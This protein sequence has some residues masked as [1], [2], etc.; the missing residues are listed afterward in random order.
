MVSAWGISR[1][2]TLFSLK[3]H[4]S[5]YFID[6]DAMRING[7][8]AL[9][10][11]ETPGWAVPAG[12]E[13]ATIYSD[14]YKLGL[15]ALRL[16]AGHHDTKILAHLP[17]TTPGLLR[18]TITDTL[19]NEPQRR[20]LP[21]AWNYVLGHAIEQAQHQKKIAAATGAPL[22][23]PDNL[24]CIRGPAGVLHR[25]CAPGAATFRTTGL[26]AT[27]E[28]T[29]LVE[30]RDMGR[31]RLVAAVVVAAVAVIAVALVIHST[32][33]TS[34]HPTRTTE[35]SF[36]AAP[37]PAPPPDPEADGF[38]S[39]NNSRPVT[40]FVNAQLADHWVPQLSSKRPGTVDPETPGVVWHNQLTLQ[41]HLR[42]RQQY[43]AKFIWSGDWPSANFAAPEYWVTVAP[44]YAI[45]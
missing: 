35:S 41:E 14:T 37:P 24:S 22:T 34:A 17:S 42:L 27:A 38:N 43:N 44:V 3:P 28:R 33:T 4:E 8:S 13:L 30:G 29:G 39:C 15:L 40:A 10:Q 31:R 32:G 23:A 16:V 7:V 12:E 11:V 5:V 20:P 6:C 36:A 1:R 19:T 2:R 21:E 26:G 25:P 18:Q 9:H 45:V